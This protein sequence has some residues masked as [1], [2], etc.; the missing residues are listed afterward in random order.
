MPPW[1]RP[2][3]VTDVGR[4]YE[5][6]E[7]DIHR[8]QELDSDD[9]KN[10]VPLG[11]GA[12]RASNGRQFNPDELYFNDMDIRAWEGRTAAVEGLYELGYDLQEEDEGYYD[13]AGEAVSHAEYEELLFRRVLDKIRVSRA[14]GN[15][16]VQLSPEE[17]EA[18]QSRLHGARVP[19][20]RPQTRSRP[21]SSPVLD[22]A[23]SMLSV[24]T[25]SR[26]DHASSGKSKSKKSQQRASLFSSKPKKEKPSSRKRAASNV[27]SGSSQVPPGFVVPGP[28]GQPM[29]TPINPYQGSLARDPE[30]LLQPASRSASGSN[31]APPES[32]RPIP[33][34]DWQREVPGAFPGAFAYATQPY[35]PTTPPR[36]GRPTT[37]RQP[38]QEDTDDRIYS[39]STQPPKLIPFPIEPY[40]YQN[41]SPS[42]SSSQPSPQLQY[43]RRPSAPPSEASYTSM[44]RRVPVPAQYTAPATGLQGNYFDPSLPQPPYPVTGV[45]DP[46]ELQGVA[47]I[48][49]LPQPV[50]VQTAKANG[51]GKDGE[52]KRKGGKS[53]KRS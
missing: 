52:R 10:G 25:T 21:P 38:T 28:D 18:Y 53:K 39:S 31:Q 23:A 47:G 45:I 11:H 13:D 5:G 44:P 30:P 34:R 43:T 33:P 20:T 4:Y 40:Q 50:P 36:Q 2:P 41:F 19:A 17:L 24:N 29:Y 27:S 16:D 35:R 7:E 15:P 8:F 6:T 49:V 12:Q 26:P 37:F 3:G 14:A 9:E 22:D 48:E 32:S 46:D 51:I 1:G 42:S